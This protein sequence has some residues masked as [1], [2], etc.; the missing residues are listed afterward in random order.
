MSWILE[1]FEVWNWFFSL[2]TEWSYVLS[3]FSISKSSLMAWNF[4]RKLLWRAKLGCIWSISDEKHPCVNPKNLHLSGLL[5]L[6]CVSWF[7]CQKTFLMETFWTSW[8]IYCSTS[9]F[10]DFFHHRATIFILLSGARFMMKI[11]GCWTMLLK[12]G[13][14]FLSQN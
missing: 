5:T 6:C 2:E 12:F 4:T 14:W 10:D 9:F 8:F 13:K 11:H 3:G 1:L 7:L